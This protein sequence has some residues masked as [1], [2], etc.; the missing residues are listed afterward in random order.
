[1]IEDPQQNE[2][3]R[4]QIKREFRDLKDLGIR[5][6][7]L[8]RGELLAIPLSEKT[9]DALLAAK[10]MTRAA[11]QRQYRYLSALLV[12]EDVA[13]I[14]AALPGKRSGRRS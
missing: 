3:S 6:A 1:M 13:A 4:S 9:R 2:K 8:S 12:E 7:G 11:L 10:G 14:R 5:L